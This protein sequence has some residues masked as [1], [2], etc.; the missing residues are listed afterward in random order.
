MWSYVKI[1][2]HVSNAFTGVELKYC[3][4]ESSGATYHFSPVPLDSYTLWRRGEGSSDEN[5]SER[6]GPEQA[7]ESVVEEGL[8]FFWNTK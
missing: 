5:R 8:E 6:R 2:R 3:R 4:V 1:D 7:P